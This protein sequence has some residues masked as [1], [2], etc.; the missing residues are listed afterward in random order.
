MRKFQIALFAL[1]CGC[2]L[3]PKV[4]PP[5][6]PPVPETA[7]ARPYEHFEVVSSRVEIRVF[8]D[9]PMAQ[10]GHDHVITSDALAGSIELREPRRDSGFTLK[11][12]LDSLVVDDPATRS[13]AGAAF[14][15][16]V[17]QADR[18]ATRRNLL[19]T[20]LLDATRQPVLSLRA[21]GLEGGPSEYLARVRVGIRG[22]ERIVGVPVSVQVAGGRISVQAS[23]R[24]RHADLG[25]TPYTVALGALRVR[26]D[27]EIDC[28]IEA[29]RSPPT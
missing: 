8:R 29:R 26:D 16:E 3:P 23:F 14:A 10:F 18:E 19:G 22:E 1:L 9:G 11:I 27:F 6:A 5:A 28:R 12:P 17:P 4:S 2:A 13:A 20:E 24:L 7:Q 25:L 15:K 21:E